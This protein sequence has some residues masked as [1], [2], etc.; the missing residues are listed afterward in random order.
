MDL[1]SE[2][3]HPRKRMRLSS[4]TFDDQVGDLSQ[5]DINAFDSLEAQLSQAPNY[6]KQLPGS[7]PGKAFHK[8]NISPLV[9][10]QYLSVDDE[11]NPFC[12]T[13][14]QISDTANVSGRERIYASFIKASAV[15]EKAGASSMREALNDS[16]IPDE[17]PPEVDYTAW[18]NSGAGNTFVGFQTAATAK[19]DALPGFQRPSIDGA[20]HKAF[21]IPSAVAFREAE[22]KMRRW[23]EDE[24][25]SSPRPTP[26]EPGS[27]LVTQPLF[28]PRPAFSNASKVFSPTQVPETPTPAPHI[29]LANAEPP[30]TRI[31]SSFQSLGGK[32]QL[33][34]FKS[35]LIAP[36][37][38]HALFQPTVTANVSS[39]LRVHQSFSPAS[40]QVLSTPAPL[41]PVRPSSVASQVM[42]QQPLGFTPRHNN[43]TRPRF[44]TPFKV[45]TKPSDPGP[46]KLGITKHTPT[47][48]RQGVVY[49]P[50]VSH[51]P[52]PSKLKDK[53]SQKIFDI[54]SPPGRKTLATSGLH[55]QAFSAEELEDMNINFKELNQIN[56]RTAVLYA[57]NNRSCA[58]PGPS[59]SSSPL[60]LG[61]AAALEELHRKGCSLATKAWIEN[62]WSLVLWKLAGMV[63]FDP[64][65]ESKPAMKRW[66]W[67]EVI[68]Q[69]MYRYE[70]DLN[71]SS[72]PPLRLITIRDASAESPMVLCVSDIIW[73]TSGCDDNDIPTPPH[74][75]LEVTDGWYRLRARIDAP[76]ARAVKKGKIRI[77][78][79]IAVTG[80]KLL[81]ERKEG[82]EI[83][84]GYDSNVLLLSGN[85]SH[86]APWHGKLG[87]QRGPFVA[88]LNSLTADGGNIAV[89]M[90]EVI[91]AFPVAYI[92]FVED[93]NGHK[94]RQGPYDAKEESKLS[95]QWKAK[96]DS[97]ASKLWSE[98]EKRQSLMVD[99]AERL[100]QRA[101]SKFT[102]E[103]EDGPPDKIYDM[104]DTMQEDPA[105]AKGVI[106]SISCQDASWLARHIRD[107]AVQE[108]ER[109][110]REVEQ[111]LES[112]CPRRE[113]R[114]F[115]VLLVK[116]AR[117][118][119]YPSKRRAQVTVWD[120][121]GLSVTEG[122]TGGPFASGQQF[123]VT[124]LVP[125]QLSAWMDRSSSSEVYLGT[126]KNSKW[127]CIR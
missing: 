81:S 33:K 99:Y 106:S 38:L 54:T 87:F 76:L 57:F 28:S 101:G 77:G 61:H 119:K 59:N 67:P 11:E 32:R 5:E 121:P 83:L 107:K 116:D 45:A 111:E 41:S 109:A 62:H 117:T 69:L 125:T 10:T 104:Y 84:E 90:F 68:R 22:E 74:P 124:N 31:R 14:G 43:T 97:H 66:C 79:K 85:S 3:S 108:R 23:E 20:K 73:P 13:Q 44:V 50:S 94:G 2:F 102:A 78:R 37:S 16:N 1:H 8:P 17:A 122:C 105:A 80:A 12:T 127:S 18:F 40:S 29:R 118:H 7:G 64:T 120:V 56:P 63:A 88:T 114:A 24:H 27:S 4:P 53:R 6:A 9:L 92:E 91:K 51:S 25:P 42:S 58:P 100:E 52:S 93:G 39:P 36:A 72:R 26:N 89:M 96:R 65:S 113:V 21:L 75:E 95:M 15:N 82:S 86:M 46:S 71:G 110:S 70:R 19:Q 98:Y 48:L 35:P 60:L 103:H 34:D 112:I 47:P 126:R 115:C 49:P 30:P 123:L 55:P